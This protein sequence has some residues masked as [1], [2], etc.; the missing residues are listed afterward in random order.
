MC[1]ARGRATTG[2]NEVHDARLHRRTS[3]GI[4]SSQPIPSREQFV[5]GRWI[6]RRRR[7][8]ICNLDNGTPLPEP[9]KTFVSRVSTP[10]RFV[11]RRTRNVIFCQKTESGAPFPARH[12]SRSFY[13]FSSYLLGPICPRCPTVPVLLSI[14]IIPLLNAVANCIRSDR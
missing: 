5:S 12:S 1:R 3:V 7:C 10:A 14:S 8:V 6:K 2:I 13:G 11:F 4:I 9:R